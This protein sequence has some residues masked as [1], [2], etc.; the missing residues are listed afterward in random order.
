MR[1]VNA[2]AHQ[3]SDSAKSLGIRAYL[4]E[5]RPEPRNQGSGQAS[6]LETD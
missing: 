6:L 4:S 1:P 5:I 3:G 2:T